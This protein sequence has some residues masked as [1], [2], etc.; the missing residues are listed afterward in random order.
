MKEDNIITEED[1]LDVLLILHDRY[2]L[3]P[4][5]G[6]ELAFN[7]P[8]DFKRNLLNIPDYRKDNIQEDSNTIS[9]S[10]YKLNNRVEYI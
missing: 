5:A 7:T 8:T 4:L 3:E 6:E 2:A 9:F 10:K 1:V